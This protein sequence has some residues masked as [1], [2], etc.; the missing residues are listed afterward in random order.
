MG[1]GPVAATSRG[2][3]ALLQKMP[4]S[5]LGTSGAPPFHPGP[6]VGRGHSSHVRPHCPVGE[7][8][9]SEPSIEWEGR[10]IERVQ[11]GNNI[12]ICFVRV[13]GYFPL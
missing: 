13:T 10:A 4:L 12:H 8:G 3:G 7:D 11:A 5:Q 2:A 9:A 6:V 1:S